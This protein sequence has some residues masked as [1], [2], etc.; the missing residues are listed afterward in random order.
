VT[1]HQYRYTVLFEPAEEGGYVVTCPSL[2]G[3]VTEG[4]TLQ[5][6]RANAAEAAI[7]KRS[8]RTACRSRP[9]TPSREAAS[10]RRRSRSLSNRHERSAG[11][12]AP[13][14]H[15]RP[16]ASWLFVHHIRG[17]HHYLRHSDRPGLLITVPVHT[18][19]LK[20]GT[21]RAIL[22]QAGL[23]PDDLRSLL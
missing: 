21:L 10:S 6:A 18:R 2:P 11:C 7:S 1:A 19:D 16:G 17:S 15:P 5:E 9:K 3:L 4:D 14:A 22:R 20:R 23:T 8:P 12:P 13:P